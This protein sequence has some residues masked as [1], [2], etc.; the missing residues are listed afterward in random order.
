MPYH[1]QVRQVRT[2]FALSQTDMASRTGISLRAYQN[3]ERGEREV[4]VALIHGLF[5][6]FGVNPVWFLTGQGDML[7][8]NGT[9]TRASCKT[10]REVKPLI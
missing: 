2:R 4:P 1:N 6:E 9:C 5:T 3:Y 8:E 7:Q 10:L